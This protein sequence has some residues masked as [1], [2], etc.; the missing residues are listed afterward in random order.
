MCLCLNE[1]KEKAELERKIQ[2]G[3]ATQKD[4]ERH[5]QLNALDITRDNRVTVA[6]Q[7]KLSSSCQTER[8]LL[9]Q[10]YAGYFANSTAS[11]YYGYPVYIRNNLLYSQDADKV[12]GFVAEYDLLKALKEQ[13]IRDLANKYNLDENRIKQWESWLNVGANVTAGIAGHKLATTT[14]AVIPKGANA[15]E[16]LPPVGENKGYSTRQ[17]NFSVKAGDGYKSIVSRV[18]GE[19]QGEFSIIKTGTLTD[20]IAETFSG[21]RYATIKLDKDLRAFRAWTPGQSNEFGAFWSLDKPLGSLQTR[22]DSALLP[23][24][25]KI[26]D[27][28]FYAQAS[29]YTEINI[30]KGTIIHIGE[31]G[32]Q[33][34]VWVGGKSQLLIENRA[35]PE[36]KIIEGVLK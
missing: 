23:E 15:N 29:K 11:N 19:I 7:N 9:N 35:N 30:P 31:V 25:G 4:K 24:W 2:Q 22:I 20:S 32:S 27:S 21:G 33:N 5:A 12:A 16:K 8:V 14:P 13:N 1:A 3:T 34:G 28:N 17:F 18:S 26:G 6:C 10:A 36:W